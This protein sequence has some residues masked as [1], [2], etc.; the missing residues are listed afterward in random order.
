MRNQHINASARR[1][2]RRPTETPPR[3]ERSAATTRHAPLRRWSVAE[4]TLLA[5]LGRPA[6]ARTR[7][8]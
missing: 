3:A 4:L 6:T 7:N 8:A 5:S 2:L 1:V